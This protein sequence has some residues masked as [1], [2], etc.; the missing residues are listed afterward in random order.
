MDIIEPQN[1]QFHLFIYSKIFRF[2]YLFII[3]CYFP[4]IEYVYSEYMQ[5]YQYPN[6]SFDECLLLHFN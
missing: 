5:W 3:Y 2:Y 1:Q 6:L 4:I